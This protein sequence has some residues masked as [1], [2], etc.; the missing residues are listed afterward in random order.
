MNGK[1][2]P[3]YYENP[4]D[5]FI[6]NICEKLNPF[7]YRYNM[8]PN[9]ITTIGNISGILS[10]YHFTKKNYKISS[11]LYF[12]RYFFDCLDGNYARK[13]NMTSNFG[14]LYDHI[15]DII[16]N[17]IIVILL[18]RTKFKYKSFWFLL[19][20][21]FLILSLIHLGCQEKKY[22]QKSI[23]TNLQK[24]CKDETIIIYTKYFGSG[25]LIL[26]ISLL[27][28]NIEYFIKN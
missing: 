21:C 14:D 4:I 20:L 9:G 7:F 16:F 27:I 15:S 5:T 6:I 24:L 11:I 23:L 26:L 28:Y 12:V 25:T 22:K 10:I 3:K 1:K 17:I 8:T 19:L 2:I 18:L 13:Y